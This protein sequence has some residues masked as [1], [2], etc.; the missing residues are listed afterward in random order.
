M[1]ELF[2]IRHGEDDPKKCTAMRLAKF[3]LVELIDKPVG[4]LLNPFAE[5]FLSP[6]DS[7]T[8][9]TALDV[10][11]NLLRSFLKHSPARKLPFLV[12]ANPINYGK[13]M[14][15]STAEA[16]AAGLWILGEPKQ[17]ELVMSK[18]KWGPHFLELNKERL[19]AYSRAKTEVEL[20]DIQ[21]E[22]L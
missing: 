1:V 2:V 16:L 15:L 9:L 21:K 3:G 7:L 20:I 8:E 18:F 4:V 13:P 12:A 10:S 17:A 19:V 5:K 14:K 22:R 11:W 6:A